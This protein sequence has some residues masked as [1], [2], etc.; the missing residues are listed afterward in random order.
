MTDHDLHGQ[1]HERAERSPN[2]AI[3]AIVAMIVVGV[4]LYFASGMPGMDHAPAAG[5]STPD[6]MS[7]MD[8]E[9]EPM[10]WRRVNPAEFE[11][12]VTDDGIVVI[13]VHVPDEGSI[14]GTD[15]TIAYDEI[16]SD[17]HLPQDRETPLAI[18]C[19]TGRMSTIAAELLTDAGYVWINEL[20]GGMRAWQRDGNPLVP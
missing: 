18:Y 14:R 10:P 4:T 12:M 7:D 5:P 1:R 11:S 6:P 15:L 8:H 20:D 3:A 9:Q 19:M 13:N 2:V 16:M 17:P